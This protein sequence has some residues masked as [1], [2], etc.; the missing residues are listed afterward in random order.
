MR[1]APVIIIVLILLFYKGYQFYAVQRIEPLKKTHFKEW[2]RC[3]IDADCSVG[4]ADCKWQPIHKKY[5]NTLIEARRYTT[6]PAAIDLEDAQPVT[7]CIDRQCEA[8]AKKTRL[9]PVA[10]ERQH[11]ITFRGGAFY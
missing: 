3:Q 1:Q 8:T 5:L 7:A 10:W 11:G 4:V 2:R 9:T 6:C